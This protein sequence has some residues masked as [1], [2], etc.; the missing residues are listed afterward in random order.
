MKR[1][2][3]LIG[4]VC[5]LL[6]ILLCFGLTPIFNKLLSGKVEI[7]RAAVLIPQGTLITDEMIQTVTV[8]SYGLPDKVIKTHAEAVGK[9][10]TAELHPDS[11]ILPSQLE[12]SLKN[13][14]HI[15][16]ALNGEKWAISVTVTDLANSLSAKIRCG[17]VV[18][19]LAPANNGEAGVIY[20]ELKFL[21]VITST[22]KATTDVDEIGVEGEDKI[23]ITITLLANERQAQILAGLSS[24]KNAHFAL[25]CRKENTELKES[26][27]TTQD[28]ILA[29]IASSPTPPAVVDNVEAAPV[30]GGVINE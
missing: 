17:D 10:A 21:E 30:D 8:G 1:N 7:V 26:L 23:P 3:T 15:L 18:S 12:E 19:I 27:L 2:R 22:N 5:I 6:A 13:S 16:S 24:A 28:K 11:Y 4:V 14:A 20:K 9:Y 29:E 25:V